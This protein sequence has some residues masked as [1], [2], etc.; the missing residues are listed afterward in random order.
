ML[1]FFNIALKK[2]LKLAL[3]NLDVIIQEKEIHHREGGG[4]EYS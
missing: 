3:N 1:T 4:G 2:W